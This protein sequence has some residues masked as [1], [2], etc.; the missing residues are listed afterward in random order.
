MSLR[1][2]VAVGVPDEVRARLDAA[3]EPLRARHPWLRWT[4]PSGWHLTMAFLGWVDEG[5]A[6]A[7]AEAVDVAARESRSFELALD[8]SLGSFGGRVLWAGISESAPLR[9]LADGV[10]AELEARGFEMES[11]PFHAHLTVARAPRDRRMPQ[12][13]AADWQ[14]PQ[15]AWQVTEALVMRSHLGRGGARYEAWS[16]LPLG[17]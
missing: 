8:G 10:R 9:T 2:F 3:L 15:D 1:L 4:D 13:L 7:V 6:G 17:G 16:R 12:A 14:G 5:R 11:R